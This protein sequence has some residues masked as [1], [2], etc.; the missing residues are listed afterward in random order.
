MLAGG[1]KDATQNPSRGGFGAPGL[2]SARAWSRGEL[3]AGD[4][5]PRRGGPA[6]PEPLRPASEAPTFQ[7][8]GYSPMAVRAPVSLVRAQ[9]ADPVPPPP[10]PPPGVGAPA[11]PLPGANPAEEAFNCGVANTPHA[12]GGFWS[13]FCDKFKGCWDDVTGSIKT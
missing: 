6:P 9:S 12:G 8:S 10:P 11:S 3:E 13:K 5:S 1:C 2:G 7:A 4:G